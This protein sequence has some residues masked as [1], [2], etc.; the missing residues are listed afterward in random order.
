MYCDCFAN[1]NYCINCGCVNCFNLPQYEDKRKNAIDQLRKKNKNA[2][3]PKV[4]NEVNK[5]EKG[6]KCKNSNCLKNYC[7][8][9]QS[10][11]ACCDNCKCMNCKN[12]TDPLNHKNVRRRIKKK[13]ISSGIKNSLIVNQR[14]PNVN[15]NNTNNNN[16][17]YLDAEDVKEKNKN[18]ILDKTVY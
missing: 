6:C 8:C 12:L 10:G 4:S 14:N 13:E 2:F 7:E 16:A 3:K 15:V 18:V 17:I 1:G 9:F 5:H 11:I